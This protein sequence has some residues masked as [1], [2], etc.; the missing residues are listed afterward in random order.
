MHSKIQ[1]VPAL[2]ERSKSSGVEEKEENGKQARGHHTKEI[3]KGTAVK[4]VWVKVPLCICSVA[5]S[6]TGLVLLREPS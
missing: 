6:K 5:V 3:W 2:C 4:T 1:L